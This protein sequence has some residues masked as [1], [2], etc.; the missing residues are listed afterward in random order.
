MDESGKNLLYNVGCILFVYTLLGFFGVA[1]AELL[2]WMIR[3]H[4]ILTSM[5]AWSIALV[6]LGKLR[7]IFLRARTAKRKL[8]E[9]QK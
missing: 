9:E 4:P 6:A 3:Q 7:E 2:Y 1:L 5:L 8:R